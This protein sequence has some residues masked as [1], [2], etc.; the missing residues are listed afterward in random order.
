MRTASNLRFCRLWN[1]YALIATVMALAVAA[2]PLAHGANAYQTWMDKGYAELEAARAQTELLNAAA[3]AH[4]EANARVLFQEI[5][6][7]YRRALDDFDTAA[8]AD[9]S[10]PNPA[11]FEA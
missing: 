2:N 4:N 6:A 5:L 8:H 11:F 9:A 3:D 10:N 1:R 7:M